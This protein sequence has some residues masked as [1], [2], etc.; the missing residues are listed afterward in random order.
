VIGIY[1]IYLHCQF[2]QALFFKFRQGTA[3]AFLCDYV[4]YVSL[5]ETF[6]LL[7][8][9]LFVCVSGP[10]QQAFE[11][12]AKGPAGRVSGFKTAVETVISPTCVVLDHTTAAT[13]IWFAFGMLT[14]DGIETAP[15]GRCAF[16]SVDA[17][18]Y[19]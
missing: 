13:A 6:Q 8:F 15:A 19:I 11:I 3:T 2:W 14:A 4:L 7:T 16:Y 10:G 9:D 17:A 5:F 12:V 18:K 1:G